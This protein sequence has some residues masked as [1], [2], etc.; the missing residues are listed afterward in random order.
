MDCGTPLLSVL[1]TDRRVSS[2]RAAN[3]DARVFSPSNRLWRLFDMPRDVS[4]LLAPTAVIHAE[5]F[6]PAIA[7]DLVETRLDD[8][9]QSPRRD[10]LQ[11]K[12]DERRR[13]TGIILVRIDRVGMP[14]EREQ[15]LGLHF[16]DHGLPSEMLIT[17]IGYLPTRNPPW[18]KWPVQPYAEPRA[19][20]MMIGERPPDAGNRGPEFDGLFDAI[21]HAQPPGC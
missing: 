20:L 3:T 14:G 11:R 2:P 6:E 15:A 1:S 5:R 9:Q 18:H 13:L 4:H 8:A 10:A 19:E 21:T 16:L 12:L 17:G 7:W